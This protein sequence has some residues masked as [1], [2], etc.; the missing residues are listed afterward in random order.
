MDERG[1]FGGSATKS[2]HVSHDR[3][4][5]HLRADASGLL[6]GQ[7]HVFWRVEQQQMLLGDAELVGEGKWHGREDK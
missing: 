1:N 2:Q 5:W 4:L 7:L 3:S 6:Q